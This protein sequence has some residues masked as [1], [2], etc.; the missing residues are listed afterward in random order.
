MTQPRLTDAQLREALTGQ[1]AADHLAEQLDLVVLS[2]RATRQVRVA[3]PRWLLLAAAAAILLVLVIAA[4]VGSAR[5]PHGGLL[6][7]GTGWDIVLVRGDGSD[8]RWLTSDAET[9]WEPTWSP[10][11]LRLAYWLNDPLA[12]GNTCGVCGINTPRRLVVVDPSVV[13]IRPTVLTSVANN[14]SWRISWSPDSRRLVVG[15]VENGVHT[16][17]IIDVETR[18]RVRLGS[19]TLDG[20]DAAWSPDGQRI[21]FAHGRDDPSQRALDLIDAG[22]TNLRH[23]TTI[24]SRGAGFGTPVWSPDGSRIAFAAETAGADPFQKDIWTVGLG[25]AREVDLSDDPADELG[26]EWSPDGFRLAWLRESS[27]GTQ[28]YRIVVAEASGARATVL[29]QIV[30]S[31]PPLWSPDGGHVLAVELAAD[32]GPGRLVA[33]D[34]RTRAEVVVIGVVPDDVGSWQPP[35]R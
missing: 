30:G 4:L 16:L 28:R 7:I 6:A 23:L 5:P 22:G 27:P 34:V 13:P 19:A 2:T 10:N 8:P 1:P 31:A 29:P 26:P 12:P 14:A 21:A 11:G 18:S 9:E 17:A 32:G 15:D 25:G 35:G 33:I 24:P 3:S 20:W